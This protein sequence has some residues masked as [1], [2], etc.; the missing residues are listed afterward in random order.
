MKYMIGVDIGTTSTKSVLYD[1]NGAFIMKHQIGYDLHTPNVDVSEENP[2][3][4][5]DAVLM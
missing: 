2:D 3:E 5:F 1:E 4:L